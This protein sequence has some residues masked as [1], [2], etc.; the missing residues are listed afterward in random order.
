M[1]KNK[2]CDP[3]DYGDDDY[4]EFMSDCQDDGMDQES[5]QSMWDDAKGS[6]AP[7]IRKTHASEVKGM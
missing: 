6:K 2:E 5:C 3:A 7:V 4:S 1:S